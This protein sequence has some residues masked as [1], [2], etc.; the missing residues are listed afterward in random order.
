[1]YTVALFARLEAKPGKENDVAKFLDAGLS[2]ANQETTTP[3]WF[4]LRLG[5]TTFGIFDAFTDESRTTGAPKRSNRQR[6]D[7]ARRPSSCRSHRP[8]RRSTSSAPRSR[9]AREAHGGHDGKRAARHPAVHRRAPRCVALRNIVPGER[10]AH[11]AEA[12]EREPDRQHEGPHGAGHDRG[13]G[14]GRAPRGRA[15]PSSNT[16]AAAPAC[17]CRWSAR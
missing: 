5:P 2:L 7:G 6:A 1:M 11:P 3:I 16:P 9:A 12:G 13:G 17:R 15:A 10:R 14:G 4:A 8:S